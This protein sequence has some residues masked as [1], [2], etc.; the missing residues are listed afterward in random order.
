MT[1]PG[2]TNMQL[3]DLKPAYVLHLRPY[4]ETSAIVDLLHA[5]GRISC[6][7]RGVR[8]NRKSA[9]LQRAILQPF[10]RLLCG[11]TGRSEL[12]TLSKFESDGQALSLQGDV[13]FSG[14]YV[15]ELLTKIYHGS[16]ESESIFYLYENTIKAM[17]VLSSSHLAELVGLNEKDMDCADRKDIVKALDEKLEIELRVFE[18]SLLEKM[19]YGIDFFSDA[20]SGKLI[21]ANDWVYRYVVE[22]GFE[23]AVDDGS[24][25]QSNKPLLITG[26]Q[27]IQLREAIAT[28]NWSDK[29]LLRDAKKLTRI[30]L[31]PL[32]AGRSIETRKLFQ[33]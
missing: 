2:S 25:R 32:L 11:W 6:V 5:E 4:R 26:S 9:Q 30:A 1:S 13:L 16:A 21:E 29:N 22:R 28:R 17:S 31:S 18:L 19:G 7:T 12:K 20:K 8:S 23:L 14:L 15:N 10:Q 33:R 27:I 24:S 3:A